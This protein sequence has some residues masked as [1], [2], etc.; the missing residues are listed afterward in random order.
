MEYVSCNIC[1]SD[2]HKVL[3]ESNLGA[4]SEL[5]PL[6]L[7]VAH[8][9]KTTGRI[10][11]CLNC[12]TIYINPRDEWRHLRENYEK[13]TEKEYMEEEDNRRHTFNKKITYLNRFIHGGKILD[14]GCQAGL[15]LS[16][17]KNYGWET[18][19]VEVSPITALY[20][21]ENY[22]LNIVTGTLEE[23]HFPEQYFDAV[24]MF[25]VL[26]HLSSPKETILEVNRILKKNGYLLFSTPNIDSV[27]SRILKRRW[28]AV[29]RSHLFYFSKKSV[30]KLLQ[31]SGFRVIQIKNNARVFRLKYAVSKL[32]QLN[33]SIYTLADYI[34]GRSFSMGQRSVSLNFG[35]DML[36]LARK[37]RNQ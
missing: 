20:A 34:I 11:K 36:V 14:V 13:L 31:S 32:K 6:Q 33:R 26:E 15:F 7:S 24:T 17:C 1:G 3:Y 37:I 25:D 18:Y 19:G 29:I 4:A 28:H 27:F 5:T 23:A 10:V 12:G 21:R 9:D 2:R 16:V 35:D 22:G 30:F 8:T